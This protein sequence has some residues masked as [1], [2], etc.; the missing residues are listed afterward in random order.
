[1]LRRV[2]AEWPVATASFLLILGA[3]SLLASGALYGDAVG[4][5]GLQQALRSAAPTDRSVIA[6]TTGRIEDVET[7]DAAATTEMQAL[8]DPSGGSFYRVIRS[9]AFSEP[10]VDEPTTDLS[11][12]AS[13][14]G[15]NEHATLVEGAWPGGGQEPIEAVLSEPAA[16]G[17]GLGV[18]DQI[19]L[20]SRGSSAVS[21]VLRVVGRYRIDRTDPYWTDDV[22]EIDGVNAAGSFTLHGPLVIDRTDLL[23]NK[24]GGFLDLQWRAI[25]NVGGIRLDDVTALARAIDLLDNRLSPAL[26]IGRALRVSSSLPEILDSVSRSV[27]V[28]RTGVLLVT[29]Q[30]AVL[31]AYALVLV[32][33]VVLDHRRT[34]TALLR[35]RGAG[36]SN[37]AAMALGEAIVLVV[38]AVLLAPL[39][40][41]GIVTLLVALGP[42]GAAGLSPD[43][44]VSSGVVVVSAL[45]GLACV[46]GLLLPVLTSG[47]SLSA[48][49]AAAARAPTRTLGQR[50]GLDLALV[51]VAGIGVWQLR[52][53]G[54]PLTKDARGALGLDPILIATPAIGLLA[55]SVLATR[56]IPRLGE[57]A[58]RVMDR[59]RGLVGA[60]G[61]RQLA[62]RPL[63]ATRS[64]LLL[65]L[66]A[67]LGTFASAHAATWTRSQADQA[68]YQAAT[69]IRLIGPSEQLPDWAV[70]PAVRVLDGVTAAM[71]VEREPLDVGRAVRNGNLLAI[72]PATA[73]SLIRF[74]DPGTEAE[75]RPLLDE[76]EASRPAVAAVPIDAGTKRLSIRLD[77][78]FA[79]P[80]DAPPGWIDDGSIQAS[81]ILA[82]ADGHLIRLTSMVGDVTSAGQRLV[83]EVPRTDRDQRPA[84]PYL[85]H[86]VEIAIDAP[87]F[88]TIHGEANVLG[89]D[90]SPSDSGDADWAPISYAPNAEAWRWSRSDFGDARPY[91]PPNDDRPGQLVAL[92]GND[93][94]HEVFGAPGDPGAIFQSRVAPASTAL[95]AIV[96]SLFLTATGSQIG[97]EIE[98]SV[99]ARRTTL[100]IVGVVDSFPPLDPA[101]AFA[102]VDIRALGVVR[103]GQTSQLPGASDWWLSVEPAKESEVATAL[104]TAPFAP[105]AVV[106]RSELASALATDPVQLGLIGALGLGAVAAV[107]FAA[108][109]F[110]VS[111]ALAAS[112]RV[113]EF[114]LLRALGLSARQLSG[115]LTLES[116][117]LLIVGLAVGGGLGLGMAWLVLPFATLTA[118]GALPVP[119]PQVVVPWETLTPGVWLALGLLIVTV[120]IVRREL[121]RVH[122]SDVLRARDE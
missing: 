7:V 30:F 61:G 84:G 96:S 8:V 37:L 117:A 10:A 53:Y 26:P 33:G 49:R 5:A 4:L 23:G 93:A 46:A 85:L 21:A 116:A 83:L 44:G 20:Q 81:V 51:V 64:A 106:V 42:L 3:T 87:D 122:L 18:G 78:A 45:A 92:E 115:W 19:A 77:A 1:V 48:V 86:A 74:A 39:I 38:P 55:G 70:G 25:P 40:A 114:A 43:V 73:S 111:A 52:L 29:L 75:A 103:F 95:P 105:D 22:L 76:L 71:P 82:D 32:A 13:Y 57:V 68:T 102:I 90:V 97:D 72:D 94:S 119:T 41:T 28:S 6:R 65:I 101:V 98:T 113:G 11:L 62:R 80:S 60:L 67:A 88:G 56:V 112:E 54:A 36:G 79:A 2:R 50:L 17:L 47:A 118:T 9:D 66:A 27:L 12:I 99:R 16:A 107:A 58:E 24:L 15:I 14:E 110:V 121:L 120:F 104:R 108:I 100:Q 63:R 59:R 35:A 109:G 31:A 34:E 69:D 91:A 89:V